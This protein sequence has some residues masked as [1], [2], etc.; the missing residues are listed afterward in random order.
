[1]RILLVV[2][3]SLSSDHAV[4]EFA[5]RR[6]PPGTIVRVLS[7][8]VNVPPSASPSV[9]VWTIISVISTPED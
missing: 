9:M 2:D 1:M 7:V 5:E 6:W 3:Y 8:V 4:T